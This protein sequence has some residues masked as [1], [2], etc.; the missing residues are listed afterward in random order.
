[1]PGPPQRPNRRA[2]RL[3]W[4]HRLAL[5]T[6]VVAV[7]AAS[8]TNEASREVR[9][10]APRQDPAGM[11][12]TAEATASLWA[13]TTDLADAVAQRDPLA[14]LALAPVPIALGLAEARAGAGGGTADQLGDA[15]H[16]GPRFDAGLGTV[17]RALPDRSGEQQDDATGR[18]GK[19]SVE[20][21]SSL[22]AQRNTKFGEPWLDTLASTWGTG[23]R[24]TDF[25]SD[26]EN[27][28]QAVNSWASDR[29]SGHISQLLPRGSLDQFTRFLAASAAYLRAPLEVPFAPVDTRLAPFTRLDGSQVSVPMMS[30]R[31]TSMRLATGDGWQAV[32]LPYLGGDVTLTIV[33]PEAGRFEQVADTLD[34]PALQALRRDMTPAPV[35]LSLPQFGF[36]S[37]LRLDDALRALGVTDAFDRGTADFAGITTDEPLSLA[38]VVHQAYL[39]LDEEG[40]DASATPPRT[41]STTRPPSGGTTVVPGTGTTV[42]PGFDGT[43]VPPGTDV[44]TAEGATTTTTAP[45]VTRVGVDRPFLALV[46]DRLTGAPM[47]Y[48]RVLSPR[49]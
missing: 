2:V 24:V 3:P 44:A 34:G 14:N 48:A 10:D 49:G 41:T 33:L 25:R 18:K 38:G 43:S 1:M 5:V 21:A 28:R 37:E 30:R 42:A 9:G 26:P 45:A 15:L 20:L 29:T 4:R 22:W 40:T 8:C 35:D 27:A 7:A 11:A 36:T 32:E 12:A 19:L 13:F 47:L 17:T 16:A 39:A 31:D 6:L 46:T 23:I